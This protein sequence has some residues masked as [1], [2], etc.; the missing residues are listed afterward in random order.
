MG[1]GIFDLL[2]LSYKNQPDRFS[3]LI[4]AIQLTNLTDTLEKGINSTQ[5][6]IKWLNHYQPTRIGGPFTLFAPTNDAFKALPTDSYNRL[7]ATPA[8]LK[9]ILLGHVVSGTYFLSGLT[10]GDL[11]TMDGRSNRIA[12]GTGGNSNWNY[13]ISLWNEGIS[14]IMSND[15]FLLTWSSNSRRRQ[16]ERPSGYVSS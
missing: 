15:L 13:S 8:E 3:L 12:I 2:Q 4:Q 16:I 7:L 14:S 11:A 5:I 10:S 9:M 6:N 1:G